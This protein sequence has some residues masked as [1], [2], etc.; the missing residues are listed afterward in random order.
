MAEDSNGKGRREGKEEREGATRMEKGREAG[1]GAVQVTY[2][3]QE[4]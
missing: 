2:F 3:C 1:R 4:I